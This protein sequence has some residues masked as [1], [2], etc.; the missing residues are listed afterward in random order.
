MH[1]YLFIIRPFERFYDNHIKYF[2][3]F[4]DSCNVTCIHGTIPK[5]LCKC[6]CNS[7]WKGEAC[8]MYITIMTVCLFVYLFIYLFVCLFIY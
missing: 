8:G 4:L 7:I 3:Y 1:Y 2:K 5:T 6:V